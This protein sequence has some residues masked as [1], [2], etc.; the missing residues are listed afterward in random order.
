MKAVLD[1]NV[2]V[3]ALM[4]A[5][6]TC[7]QILRLAF[8]GV[9]KLCLDARVLN[10]HAKVLPRPKF[11][12]RPERVARTLDFLRAE[13]EAVTAM[14]LTIELPDDS[15]L[16]FLEVAAQAQAILVT[17]NLRHFPEDR[18]AGVTVLSPRQ[19]L[20]LLSRQGRS[21]RGRGEL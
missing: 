18:R 20:D 12:I 14:P 5:G 11:R 19:F 9:V 8:R 4:T 1:T 13:A 7:D 17:G 21:P 16:P 10:E 6:G 2:L 3:S 15:D